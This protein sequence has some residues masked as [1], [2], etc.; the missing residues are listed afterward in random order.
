MPDK[1]RGLRQCCELHQHARQSRLRQL[2]LGL[3]RHWGHRLHRSESLF[4]DLFHQ[5]ALNCADINECATNHGNRVVFV[6]EFS[7]NIVTAALTSS[8]CF[9]SIDA[10]KK[11]DALSRTGASIYPGASAATAPAV[12]RSTA[13]LASVTLSVCFSFLQFCLARFLQM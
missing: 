1:S 2:S 5:S 4:C 10:C 11:E 12:S 13:P 6:L 3:R 8:N 7:S 9:G